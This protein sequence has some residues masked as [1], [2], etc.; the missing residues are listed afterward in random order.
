[1]ILESYTKAR[2]FMLP[3]QQIYSRA[4]VIKKVWQPKN[5]EIENPEEDTYLYGQK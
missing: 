4:I 2:E 3:Y 1:M 5:K